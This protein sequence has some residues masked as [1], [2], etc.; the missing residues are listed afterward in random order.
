MSRDNSQEYKNT[1]HG[2]KSHSP[3]PNLVYAVLFLL[4]TFLENNV[5]AG[6]WVVFSELDLARHKLL[7]LARPIDL[8]GTLGF[9]LY[10]LILRHGFNQ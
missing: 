3:R 5:F 6:L 2:L 7:I 1:R 8:W 10:E 4:F 9:Q